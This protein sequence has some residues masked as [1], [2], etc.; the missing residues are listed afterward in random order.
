MNIFT[1][2]ILHILDTIFQIM[3][4]YLISLSHSVIQKYIYLHYHVSYF[5]YLFI[6]Y[7]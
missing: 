2:S 1:Y 5:I 4:I 7:Y 3:S 6:F